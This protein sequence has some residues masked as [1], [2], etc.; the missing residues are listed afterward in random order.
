MN[1]QQ[2]VAKAQSGG[3]TRAQLYGELDRRSRDLIAPGVSKEQAF[4]K[5]CFSEE[6]RPLYD[7]YKATEGRD[8]EPVAA[9]QKRVAVDD[10]SSLVRAMR[11]AHGLTEHEAINRCLQTEGGRFAFAKVKRAQQ[12]ATG[13]F[14][15]ADM[16]CSDGV[17]AD[18][19]QAM[20]KRDQYG[21][22]SEYE[23]E[24]DAIRRMYPN[25]K[26]SDVHDHARARNPEAWEEH[27]KLNKMGG[28]KLPQSRQQREQPGDED[29][30]EPRSGRTQPDRSP[31]WRGRHSGSTPTTPA[32]EPEHPSDRPAIKLIDDLQRHTGLERERLIPILKRMP[33]GRR[34]LNMAVAELSSAAR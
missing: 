16:E 32:R 6:G 8:F 24:C 10:W 3:F 26:M 34:L 7:V 17:S 30:Q 21:V 28:G 22:K 23:A 18:H 20:A 1:I 2:V 25:M 27:K 5:F 29:V 19:D 11:K 4:A 31:Q 15:K 13:Q 9:V 14:T 33:V 12:V